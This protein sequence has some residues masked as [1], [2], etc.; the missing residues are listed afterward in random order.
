MKNYTIDFKNGFFNFKLMTNKSK[1][2]T[3]FLNNIKKQNPVIF[4]KCDSEYIEKKYIWLGL[5]N[6]PRVRIGSI[7]DQNDYK[8]IF[9]KQCCDD[10]KPIDTDNLLYHTIKNI[11][12]P[13]VERALKHSNL[14][15]NFYK[16]YLKPYVGKMANTVRNYTVNSISLDS[17]IP[18]V[19]T[20]WIKFYNSDEMNLWIDDVICNILVKSSQEKFVIYNNDKTKSVKLS[21]YNL[22]MQPD[23]SLSKI[24]KMLDKK[25]EFTI[26]SEFDIT[27]SKFLDMNYKTFIIYYTEYKLNDC[28]GREYEKPC[29]YE[30]QFLKSIVRYI[31]IDRFNTYYLPTYLESMKYKDDDMGSILSDIDLYYTKNLSTLKLNS[32]YYKNGIIVCDDI[33]SKFDNLDKGVVSKK[34]DIL[35]SEI[36]SQ[37]N[38]LFEC[39][40]NKCIKLLTEASKRNEDM[41]YSLSAYEKVKEVL[42][43]LLKN[44]DFV[45]DKSFNF[46]FLERWNEIMSTNNAFFKPEEYIS[47][48]NKFV[49]KRR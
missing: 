29:M 31:L 11:I 33:I 39:D 28:I 20:A 18:I 27:D 26:P 16:S 14:L 48:N 35:F 42:S 17:I 47:S 49:I 40:K 10:I 46:S 15:N 13:S 19:E 2:L 3:K 6:K 37:L 21:L 22:L 43:V 44:N 23:Y 30:I 7:S 34:L 5:F 9:E 24:S 38:N 32:E 12:S 45:I 1:T 8:L 25:L 36:N 4:T 41:T